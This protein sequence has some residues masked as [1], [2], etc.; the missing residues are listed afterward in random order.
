MTSSP[1]AKKIN[2]NVEVTINSSNN[3]SPEALKWLILAGSC[4]DKTAR[5]YEREQKLP[6][7]FNVK[8]TRMDNV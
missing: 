8:V 1:K 3:L 2:F 7:L 5:A 6:D 4:A